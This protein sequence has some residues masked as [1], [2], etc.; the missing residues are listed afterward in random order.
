MNTYILWYLCIWWGGANGSSSWWSLA[1]C[2]PSMCTTALPL[3]WRL[4]HCFEKAMLQKSL[5]QIHGVCQWLLAMV[6]KGNLHECQ[7]TASEKGHKL[8]ALLLA[9]Q[10]YLLSTM[11]DQDAGIDGP[12]VRSSGALL[13][14]LCILQGALI[15]KQQTPLCVDALVGIY[16]SFV[17]FPN[18]LRLDL[19]CGTYFLFLKFS[20]FS[21]AQQ[22][23]KTPAVQGY[24]FFHGKSPV[25]QTLYPWK[26][27]INEES[28]LPIL[29]IFIHAVVFLL[30]LQGNWAV[31]P[32]VFWSIAV[33]K[34]CAVLF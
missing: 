33:P 28:L 26:I 5:R 27:S 23:E 2:E 1:L 16:Q 15:Q 19:W 34:D 25:S 7:E 17:G 13:M 29:L 20:K 11:C 21:W 8:Y 6:T 4:Y 32:P 24:K 22:S 12:L 3:L 10:R 9:L 31:P 14:F 30:L 18:S